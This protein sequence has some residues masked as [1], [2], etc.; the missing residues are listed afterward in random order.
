LAWFARFLVRFDLEQGNCPI[1][2]MCPRVAKR[3]AMKAFMKP[4]L[5]RR[6]RPTES[7]APAESPA[8]NI[9]ECAMRG[10]CDIFIDEN[11]RA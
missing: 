1:D 5:R 4:A 3:R 10:A 11:S 7:A 6:R 8:A 2:A 9:F